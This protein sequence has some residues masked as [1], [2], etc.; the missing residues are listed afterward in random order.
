[1]TKTTLRM[2]QLFS[3]TTPLL[4]EIS[5]TPCSMTSYQLVPRHWLPVATRHVTLPLPRPIKWQRVVVTWC[6][7]SVMTS[8]QDRRGCL[9][10]VTHCRRTT[11]CHHFSTELQVDL[12]W[13]SCLN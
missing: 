4:V 10:A 8:V 6:R 9:P 13:S 3:T 2:L 7:T 11:D 1:V 5:R 12:F